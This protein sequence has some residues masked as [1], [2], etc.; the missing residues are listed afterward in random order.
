MPSPGRNLACVQFGACERF[1]GGTGGTVVECELYWAGFAACLEAGQMSCAE[2]GQVTKGGNPGAVQA[3]LVGDLACTACGKS[4]LNPVNSATTPN[5]SDPQIA[6]Q[7][8]VPHHRAQNQVFEPETP[9][10]T[11]IKLPHL[12]TYLLHLV[13]TKNVPSTQ[14]L[15]FA[16]CAPKRKQRKK[17]EMAILFRSVQ[18]LPLS[19]PYTIS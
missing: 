7:V 1:K 10:E 6:V 17:N 13:S 5:C 8:A 12:G 2:G 14:T 4:A 19:T 9:V 11:S 16:S 15:V 18:G 3:V